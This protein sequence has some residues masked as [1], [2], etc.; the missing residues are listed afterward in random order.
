MKNKAFT[1]IEGMILL[2]IIGLI[3]VTA[4]TAIGAPIMGIGG[5]GPEKSISHATVI[6]KHVDIQK[7]SD[8]TSSHYMV[9]TNM[10]TFEVDNGFLLGIWNSD[11]IYGGLEIG[12]TYTFT[13]KGEKVVG[14]FFQYYPYIIKAIPE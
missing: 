5:F 12:K 10:G 13:T 9:A 3:A 1:S 4:F 2:V 7:S 14:M 8:S 11:E 6:S